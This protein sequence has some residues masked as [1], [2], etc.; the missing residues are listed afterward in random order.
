MDSYTGGT[1]EYLLCART[2]EVHRRYTVY[3][4]TSVLISTLV[5][6]YTKEYIRGTL[7]Y[8]GVPLLS[9][10]FWGIECTHEKKY[11]RVLLAKEKSARCTSDFFIYDDVSPQG[12]NL[13]CDAFPRTLRYRNTFEIGT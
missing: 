13:W 7:G 1:P 2:Q 5:Y 4:Y 6:S 11:T 8:T 3:S 9:C 10:S 12:R